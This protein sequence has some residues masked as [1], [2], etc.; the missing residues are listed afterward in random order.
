MRVTRWWRRVFGSGAL[1]AEDEALIGLDGISAAEVIVDEAMA[2][3][4]LLTAFTIAQSRWSE[5]LALAA[6]VADLTDRLATRKRLDRA[7]SVLM[8]Q[9]S[10]DEAA[11]FRWIQKAAMD[12]RLG[13]REVADAIL[14]RAGEIPPSQPQ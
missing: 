6:E 3:V 4:V 8:R 1:L 12:R 13:M 9:L 5:R 2:P 11:A 10:L 14:L 7:K